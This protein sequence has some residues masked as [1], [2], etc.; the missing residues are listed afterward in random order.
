MKNLNEIYI[1]NERKKDLITFVHPVSRRLTC[2]AGHHGVI[3]NLSALT[4]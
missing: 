2:Q 4:T 1:Y 3:S